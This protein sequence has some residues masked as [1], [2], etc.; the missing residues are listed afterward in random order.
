[1]NTIIAR[2]VK[3][4]KRLLF[5]APV[6]LCFFSFAAL[7]PATAFAAT[8]TTCAAK[9]VKC[10]IGV[11][12]TLI[13]NRIT[14]LNNLN[15]KV[16]NDHTAMLISDDAASSLQS[17]IQTNIT[18]LNTLKATLDAETDA[19]AARQDVQKIYTQFRIYAV[20]LPRDTRRLQM[21]IEITVD[22][23]FTAL[24]SPIQQ[25]INNAPASKQSQLNSLFTDY[26]AQLADAEQN[27]DQAQNTWPLLT[28][29][30]YNNARATYVTNLKNLTTDVKTA[31]TDLHKAGSDLHQMAQIL[32]TA[33]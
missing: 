24:E 28:P 2:F 14:S 31:H 10:V 32:K 9:D 8:T 18:G 30:S 6:L 16:T 21:S 19:T 17:D 29:D 20:V 25:L 22:S 23:K 11:G 15:T 33:I 4:P 12:D 1:M 27:I 5:A 7:L 13:T 26:K 3:F